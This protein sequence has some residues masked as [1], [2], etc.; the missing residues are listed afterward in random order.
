[1]ASMYKQNLKLKN[2]AYISF[3]ASRYNKLGFN[4]H[5]DDTNPI[6][7]GKSNQYLHS[8]STS[9]KQSQ[10]SIL[11]KKNEFS[12]TKRDSNS[13]THCQSKKGFYRSQDS[14]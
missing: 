6:K 10:S 13:Q 8:N 4:L 9:T 12:T 14:K 11:K 1:M 7:R 3:K 5:S 2:I